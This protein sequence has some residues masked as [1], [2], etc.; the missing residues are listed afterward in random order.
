VA[1]ELQ[2]AINVAPPI[3]SA[4]TTG[5][6]GVFSRATSTTAARYQIPSGWKGRYV[7]FYAR[8]YEA[9]ILFGDSTVDCSLD[10]NSSVTS[11]VITFDVNTGYPIP[12][13]TFVDFYIPR[14]KAVTHFSI[15]SSNAGRIFAYAAQGRH[16]DGVT[17]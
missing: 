5:N 6:D 10:E 11:E 2:G 7:R 15:D 1:A 8:D 14:N 4:G 17:A 9:Q 13:G 12:A 3:A 16:S